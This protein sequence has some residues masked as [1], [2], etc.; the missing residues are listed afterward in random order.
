VLKDHEYR[1]M[2]QLRMRYDE[3]HP[4]TKGLNIFDSQAPDQLDF[5]QRHLDETEYVYFIQSGSNGS[6][7][8]GLS[9]D[10]ERRLRQLQTGNLRELRL[11]HVVPGTRGTENDLHVRFAPAR[12]RGEWFGREY[13]AII[14]AFA[15]GLANEMV[16]AYDG[17]GG[18]P[19]LV[20]GATVRTA[21][22]LDR[23]RSDLNRLYLRGHVRIGELSQYTGLDTDE[24]LLHL[25]AMGQSGLYDVGRNLWPRHRTG[26]R[27][28]RPLYRWT[29]R[30]PSRPP[31]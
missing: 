7:K 8:I 24:V 25:D 15:G 20:D 18:A 4:A 10:P 1:F 3:L 13:L 11:R 27:Q 5:W 23:I 22:D 2:R 6:V 12:I 19:L 17:H 26:R 31:G 29:N 14:L 9:N 16:A 30:T 21:A 28:Q